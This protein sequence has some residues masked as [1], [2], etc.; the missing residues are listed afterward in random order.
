M[1]K[2]LALSAL[3]A[4]L[5][6]APAFAQPAPVNLGADPATAIA[7]RDLPPADARVVQAR[8]W[9]KK[10]AAATGENEEQVAASCMKL[11]KFM[12]DGMRVRALPAEALEGLALQAAPGKSL[13][14]LTSG[15]YQARR[16]AADKSHAG[17]MA[18]MAARK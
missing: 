2:T 4:L 17:A 8:E 13:S 18:A 7:G 5:A 16:A 15:Y 10:V 1:K 11:V 3:L 9:L 14:D 6:S 12:L